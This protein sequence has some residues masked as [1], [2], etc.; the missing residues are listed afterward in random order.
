MK[1]PLFNS[2]CTLEQP[3]FCQVMGLMVPSANVKAIM[4]F[5]ACCIFASK[6]QGSAYAGAK[7]FMASSRGNFENML[8]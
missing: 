2:Y 1:R 6:G 8:F 3:P 5:Y 7:D 4:Y